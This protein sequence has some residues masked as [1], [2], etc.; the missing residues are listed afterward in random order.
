MPLSNVV[1]RHDLRTR[2]RDLRFSRLEAAI[3]RAAHTTRAS[4][5]G[6]AVPGRPAFGS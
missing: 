2:V 1:P 4:A 5:Q 3:G 6:S